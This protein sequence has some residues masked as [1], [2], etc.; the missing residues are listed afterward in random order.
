MIN[1]KKPTQAVSLR[2]LRINA[3]GYDKAEKCMPSRFGYD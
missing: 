3:S 2:S 1:H